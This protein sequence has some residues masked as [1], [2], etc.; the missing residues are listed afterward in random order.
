M[1]RLKLGDHWVISDISGFKFP[2]SEMRKLSGEQKGLVC[3]K[4]E[5]N[6]Q[7]PQ[8]VLRTRADKQTVKLVRLRGEDKFETPP[9]PEDL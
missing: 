7:H 4:S 3:H 5:W 2:A 6:P 9:K 1:N 8:L